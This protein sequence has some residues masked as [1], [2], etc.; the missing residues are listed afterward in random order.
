MTISPHSPTA[1]HVPDPLHLV[2]D[3]NGPKTIHDMLAQSA[4]RSNGATPTPSPGPSRPPL[5]PHHRQD[6]SVR[7]FVDE[8]SRT[9]NLQDPNSRGEDT[10]HRD[11]PPDVL[12]ERFNNLGIT[13]DDS[14]ASAAP[15]EEQYTTS[16]FQHF[17]TED[18]HH[19]VTGREG[20]LTRCEDE[21]I[22][23]PGA[24]QSF[25]VLIV[26]EEDFD[27]GLLTVRQVSE[28]SKS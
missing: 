3:S 12:Q 2:D 26:L 18:G 15:V 14:G 1:A 13:D 4:R 24:I 11:S 8:Q 16:R 21:P 9:E 5:K 25:G 22:T 23:S 6:K 7:D 10:P 27:T 20:K 28:V 17:E 19:V